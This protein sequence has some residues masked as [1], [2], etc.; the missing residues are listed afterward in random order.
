MGCADAGQLVAQQK[1]RSFGVPQEEGGG[2]KG[3]LGNIFSDAIQ[4]GN[5]EPSR[6]NIAPGMSADQFQQESASL[7]R[8][9]YNDYKETYIQH[10]NN[11]LQYASDKNKFREGVERDRGQVKSGLDVAEGMANRQMSRYGT[12]LTNAQQKARKRSKN[13]EGTNAYVDSANKSR[14]NTESR[15]DAVRGSMINLGRETM[16]DSANQMG[17]V[18]EQEKGRNDRYKAAK[19]NYKSQQTQMIGQGLGLG[20]ML[21]LGSSKSLKKNIKP[22]SKETA[23]KDVNSI[24]LKKFD[25]K[26]GEGGKQIGVIRE[27]APKSMQEPDGTHIN[28]GSWLG[29]LTG[30]V[31]VISE[32]LDKMEAK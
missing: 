32:K 4:K 10:E 15:R 17:Q 30:A 12:N 2:Q 21:L 31:Q 22:H 5:A 3:D 8:S 11:M 24:N 9:M 28:V 19:A 27:D 13:V 6:Y 16:G 7:S 20:G 18:A 1:V 29:N 26:E 14:D 23:Y 25:Y